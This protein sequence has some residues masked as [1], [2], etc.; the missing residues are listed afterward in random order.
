MVTLSGRKALLQPKE[1]AKDMLYKTG[2]AQNQVGGEQVA[3]IPNP[4]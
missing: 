4:L 2:R 1:H 3:K